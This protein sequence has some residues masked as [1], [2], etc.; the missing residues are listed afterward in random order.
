MLLGWGNTIFS[1]CS[2]ESKSV[3]WS[4]VDDSDMFV[5]LKVIALVEI[6][7]LSD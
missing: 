2:L 5:S 6:L 4:N 7:T 3:S 1:T